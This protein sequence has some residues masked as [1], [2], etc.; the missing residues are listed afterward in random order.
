MRFASRVLAL[1]LL[2]SA[3]GDSGGDIIEPTTGSIQITTATNGEMSATEYT[4]SLDGGTAQP[5]VSNATI[6]ITDQPVGSHTLLLTGIASNCTLAEE[7]PR[8]FSVT[9]GSTV[10]VRFTVTCVSPNALRWTRMESGSTAFLSD[11]WGSG[12]GDVYV[13][14]EETGGVVLHYDGQSW[15]L[16]HR[17][18]AGPL[19]GVWASAP[20]D[21]FAVGYEILHYDGIE[22]STM[23][24][25]DLPGDAHYHAVWGTSSSNIY[26]VGD[27]FTDVDN[28]VI[29]HYDGSTWSVVDL[30]VR[31]DQVGS[32]V[33]GTSA[34]DVYVTG[35]AFKSPPYGAFALHYD[36]TSWSQ[37]L[38][39]RGL[40]YSIWANAPNDVFAGGNDD[41]AGI[42]RH[43]DGQN[44]TQTPV[45]TPRVRSL[46]GASASDVYAAG[47]GRVFHFD[48]IAWS[49][50]LDEEVQAVWGA[51]ATDVFMVGSG[52][53]ILHGTR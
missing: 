1:S 23:A 27:Y 11:V 25:P 33:H 5:I 43:F 48:G 36:G 44:W 10:D 2:I 19:Y 41:Q 34:S 45:S 37:V 35:L 24:G 52:G 13:T 12:P 31:A 26:A 30:G 22:W 3:C 50:V 42:I 4:V 51:S 53:L 46:W 8:T 7:N 49:T 16:A 29:A 21:V 6:E 28:L 17:S 14:G 18:S 40:L 32:N 47:D 39:E 20:N 9:A 15:S 38:T